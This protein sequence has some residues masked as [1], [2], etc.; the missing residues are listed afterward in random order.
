MLNRELDE[1]VCDL[2]R[3]H[4]ERDTSARDGGEID[5]DPA[6]NEKRREMFQACYDFLKRLCEHKHS[7]AQEKLFPLIHTFSDHMGIKDLNVADTLSAVVR[8]NASLC[9]QVP[10]SLYE[11]FIHSILTWGRKPRWLSFFEVFISVNGTISKRN[12]DKILRLM[13]EESSLLDLD[14]DYTDTNFLSPKDERYGKKRLDL[15]IIRD[16]KRK[17]ASLLK[18]HYVSIDMLA[19]CCMGKNPLNKTKVASKLPFETILDNILECNLK[20]DGSVCEEVDY[21]TVCYVKKVWVRLLLEVYLDSV[22]SSAIRDVLGSTR[23]WGADKDEKGQP[24]A[25]RT[26]LI[27][28]WRDCVAKLALRLSDLCNAGKEAGEGGEGEAKNDAGGAGVKDDVAKKEEEEQ[29]AK[30]QDEARCLFNSFDKDKSGDLSELELENALT[31]IGFT[32][33]EVSEIMMAADEDSDGE[34]CTLGFILSSI[35]G[36]R[37]FCFVCYAIVMLL[38]SCL[39]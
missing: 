21:D 26:G 7:R 37:S 11:H 35:F 22:E 28:E 36:W 34:F 8:N 16:H 3:L 24:T 14:C 5:A 33:S 12:Q 1:P 13:M 25:D 27:K 15:M 31:E 19:Q 6:V 30:L 38:G 17:V 20:P 10:E 29:A 18:Y 9:A 39:V 23:I 2:L 32:Q 4:L